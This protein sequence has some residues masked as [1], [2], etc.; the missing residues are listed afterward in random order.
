MNRFLN[1]KPK[2]TGKYLKPLKFGLNQFA[3]IKCICQLLLLSFIHNRTFYFFS[4]L[5]NEKK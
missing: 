2:I 3:Y 5:I 4:N 1:N